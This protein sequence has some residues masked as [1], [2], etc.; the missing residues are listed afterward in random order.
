MI[1]FDETKL[2]PND[3]M[4]LDTGTYEVKYKNDT[5]T[6]VY[7]WVYFEDIG[8]NYYQIRGSPFKAEFSNDATAKNGTMEG[9]AL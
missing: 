6:P 2:I 9:E 1:P 8:E 7:I 3:F 4:D 5:T